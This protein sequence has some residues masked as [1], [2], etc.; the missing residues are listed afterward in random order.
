MKIAQVTP[1][2]YP[3]EGGVERHVYSLSK[4]LHERGHEVH[5]FTYRGD[6]NGGKLCGSEFYDGLPVRRFS[7]L[8]TLG[9]FARFWPGVMKELVKGEFDVVHAHVYRHPHS[10]ISLIASKVTGSRSVLTAHSPFPPSRMRRRFSR[11]MVPL[12]DKTVGHFMLN[13]FDTVIS[14]TSSEAEKLTSL[15]LENSKLVTIPHGVDPRH[16]EK[17]DAERFLSRFKLHDKRYILY[18]G[19]INKTKGLEYLLQAFS[20]VSKEYEDLYLVLAGPVTDREEEEYNNKLV[21]ETSQ[22]G[23][24]GKV[25]FTGPLSEEEK[26]AAYESCSVFVLPSVY[27]PYGI[28]LLEAAAHG[29]PLVA[30]YTDGP[31]SIIKDRV[32][33]LLVPPEDAASLADSI[34]SLMKD[35]DSAKRMGSAARA[36]AEGHRWDKI[37]ESIESVYRGMNGW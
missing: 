16:F 31:A 2:F 9:E 13:G 24:F 30:S 12:Y 27:E 3:V 23:I 28:V 4:L 10:D 21:Y 36:M 18:L 33:G 37:V 22:L 34:H 17:A 5:V 35:E 7:S 15:G 14:L 6:R 26:L 32:N 11:F 1:Y 25:I 20:K 29:K 8:F 19:R